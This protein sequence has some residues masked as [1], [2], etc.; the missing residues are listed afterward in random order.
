MTFPAIILGLIREKNKKKQRQEVAELKV[1][2]DT[3]DLQRGRHS[4]SRF[5]NS[6]AA[7][8]RNPNPELPLPSRSLPRKTLFRTFLGFASPVRITNNISS[9]IPSFASVFLFFVFSF[10]L[11]R[12]GQ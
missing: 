10:L 4:R 12:Q 7:L 1:C 2:S 6:S 8:R 11:H 9:I 5:Q 3:G